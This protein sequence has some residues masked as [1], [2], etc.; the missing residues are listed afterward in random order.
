MVSGKNIYFVSDIHLGNRFMP[1]P[2]EAEKKM[3]QWLDD[4]K[5]DASAVYFLGDIFDYWFEYKYVA[6]RGHV[7]FLGKLA[8]LSDSGI[9]IHLLIGNH[10]IWMFDYLPAE[11]GAIIHHKPFTVE[12][13]GK[14]F[15]LGHGDE[16]GYR[17]FMYRFIQ[18]IFR[19]RLCQV[20]YATIHPRWSFGFARGWS[21]SSRKSG[22]NNEKIKLAQVRNARSLE[23]FARNILQSNPDIHYFMF[24]HL[25]LLL[26]RIIT[27]NTRLIITGDWM[28]LFSYAVW[29]GNSMT[30]KQLLS[31]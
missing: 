11:I 13:L 16:V 31:S 12:L 6:P 3:V 27:P 7:R 4:I 15:F 9:E 30:L 29:D 1:N 8:E 2:L 21:L 14:N 25:H 19:N 10:D 17:P 23:G 22:M 20:L 26:D 24:G 5:K 28:Q 18:S